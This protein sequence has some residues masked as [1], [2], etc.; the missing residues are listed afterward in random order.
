MKVDLSGKVALVTGGGRGI[1]RA[2]AAKLA[3][4]GASVVVATRTAATGQAVVDE[5]VADGGTAQLVA[6][7]LS[8]SA[9]CHAAVAAAA[10]A[11]GGLDILVHN[12]AI[13]PFTPFAQLADE[14]FDRVMRTNLYSVKWLASAALPHFAARSGGRMIAIASLIGNRS[15]LAGLDAYAA[16]KA[17]MTGLCKS[18]ALEFAKLEATVN[19]I[20][21]GLIIDD[22]DP[23]M[24]ESTA[25]QIVSNIPVMRSGLPSDI[26]NAVLF[27]ASPT[28]DFVTGQSL[29][30]DGGHHLPDMSAYAMG[31]HL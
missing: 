11:F 12:S 6:L 24:D 10:E 26:A 7:D 9:A 19:L 15:W 5:I 1:G 13:F 21:P 23:R 29:A 31:S 28:S 2:I 18:L 30:V 16:S 3:A 14:E 8:S 20:E 17:G 27:F 25:R 22:R 4:S